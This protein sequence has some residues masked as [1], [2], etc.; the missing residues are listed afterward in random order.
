MVFAT[1]ISVFDNHGINS[2]ALAF[3]VRSV[4]TALDGKYLT[5]KKYI[6]TPFPAFANASFKASIKSASDICW[7]V[8]SFWKRILLP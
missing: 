3:S 4:D 8:P 1:Q 7:F 6:P 2:L 5:Y